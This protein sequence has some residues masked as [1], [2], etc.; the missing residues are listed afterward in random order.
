MILGED[1]LWY[2]LQF[3]YKWKNI[4]LDIAIYIAKIKNIFKKWNHLIYL[5]M[6]LICMQ[7]L[8]GKQIQMHNSL[9]IYMV[10]LFI[11]LPT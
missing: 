8:Y 4:Y 1:F 9:L 5:Q 3:F 2:V 6:C 11:A 10:G 7:D